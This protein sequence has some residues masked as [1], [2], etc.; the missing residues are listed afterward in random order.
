M[1]PRLPSIVESLDAVPES[2]RE[3]YEKREGKFYIGVEGFDHGVAAEKNRLKALVKDLETKVSAYQ[4]LGDPES[5]RHMKDA[6]ALLQEERQ[7][8][9]GEFDQIKESL[10]KQIVTQKDQELDTERQRTQRYRAELE[11]QLVE[12]HA[13][14][15]IMAEGGYPNALMPHIRSRVKVEETA[16]GMDVVVTGEDGQPRYKADGSAFTMRDLVVEMKQDAVFGRLFVRG[17]TGGSGAPA[18]Q[19]GGAGGGRAALLER[20]RKMPPVERMAEARRLG[21]S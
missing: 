7:R 11:R 6:Q 3:L 9:A 16:N 20:L 19:L 10:R 2:Y 14:N 18:H 4:A 17:G 12:G 5:L 15:L 13:E 1:A 8:Q 21:V